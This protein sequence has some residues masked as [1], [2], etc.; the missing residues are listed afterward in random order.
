MHK[1]TRKATVIIFHLIVL[2]AFCLILFKFPEEIIKIKNK[3]Y[4]LVQSSQADSNIDFSEYPQM[5]HN[6]DEWFQDTQLVYHAGGGIDGLDYSNSKEALEATLSSGNN[7]IEI[8]FAYTSDH[9]LVCMHEWEEQ[10]SSENIPSLAE[11]AS[12]KIFG[13]YTPMTANDVVKYM[14]NHPELYVVIDTKED[15]HPE[16]IRNLT[17]LSSYDTSITDRFII[18]LYKPGIKEQILEIYPF[19]DE[20]FLF[21]AYKFGARFPNKIMKIC[22]DENIPVVTVPYGS[23]DEQAK[24][25]FTSKNFIIYEHTVNR[26]DYASKSLQ[27]GVHGFYTDFLTEEDLNIE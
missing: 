5:S 6:G 10:W 2:L 27:M 15:D 19:K 11:F 22:Y 16:V 24:E 21:T 26:P 4:Y 9:Q 8:D 13:K 14:E 1:I 23:W 18:Q 3:I 17:E 25:L 20:N 7:V 12:Q